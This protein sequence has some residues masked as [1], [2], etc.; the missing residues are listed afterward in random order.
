MFTL[1]HAKANEVFQTSAGNFGLPGVIDLPTA[2]RFPDGELIITHQNHEYLLMTGISFQA[3]PRLGVA[4]RYGGRGRGGGFAQ[5][6][7]IGIE[8][9]MHIYL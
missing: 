2:R 3:L 5:G 6:E 4:F 9:S 8:V 1:S 7:L